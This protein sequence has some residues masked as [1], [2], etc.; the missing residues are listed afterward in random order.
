MGQRRDVHELD[1]QA[2][3]GVLAGV[4]SAALRPYERAARVRPLSLTPQWKRSLPIR[5]GL[6]K[7]A[8]AHEP[9]RNIGGLQPRTLAR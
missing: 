3:G 2:A 4:S 6:V 7:F 9:P 8:A 5:G 1:G